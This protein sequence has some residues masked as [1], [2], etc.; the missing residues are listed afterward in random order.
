MR[1]ERERS[2]KFSIRTVLA[3]QYFIYFGVLGIF[4]PYFNLY[5][6]HLSFSGLQIGVLS[7]IQTFAT[8]VFPLLWAVLADR[9]QSRRLIYV[10]CNLVSTA[11]WALLLWTTAFWPMF[12]IMLFY[13]VFHAPIISF[14][15]AFTMDLMG[16]EKRQ[17]GRIRVWGSIN[18]IFAVVVFGRLIDAFS[19]NII[20]G[21]ILAGSILRAAFS[22]AVPAVSIERRISFSAGARELLRPR[23][24]VFLITSLMMLLSHGTYYGFFSIH[25]ETLGFGSTFIGLAWGLASTAEILVMV[26]SDTIFKRFSLETVLLFS[27]AVATFRWVLLFFVQAP[28]ML[29]LSQLLHAFTYGSFHIAGIL[30]IDRLIPLE[31]KTF[32]QAA[33]NAMTYGL[34]IAGGFLLNG[35]FFESLGAPVLFLVSGLIAAAG[36]LILGGSLA[37]HRLGS[38]SSR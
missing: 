10:F 37:V 35:Y 19:V 7:S 9:Y 2:G 21:L 28:G 30:Y 23:L 14:L 13:G 8:V 29:L 22:L 32:G 38:A 1:I 16:G 3:G 12:F 33:N 26:K 31:A 15:E 36:G 25:L 6:Y 11:I 17:Y 34:G 27:F 4:L 18:F 24:L 20:V 5:C